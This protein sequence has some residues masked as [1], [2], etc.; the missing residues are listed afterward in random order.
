LEK[1]D[2]KDKKILNELFNDS[3]QSFRSVGR[4]VGLS[5]DVVASRVNKLIELGIIERFYTEINL[6]KLGYLCFRFYISFQNTT[7]QIKEEIIKYFKDCKHSFYV[8]SVRGEYELVL[9]ILFKRMD[10]FFSFWRETLIKYRNY[11]QKQVI[12]AYNQYRIYRYKFLIDEES[13]VYHKNNKHKDVT[14]S[15]GEIVKTDD[16][17][18]QILKLLSVNSRVSTIEIAE[19]LNS[20][21]S[22][23][24]ARIKKLK[25]VDV[26]QGYT[27]NI[28]HLALDYYV[29]KANIE[30]N[31]YTKRAAM[32]EYIEKN[33][34]LRMIDESA[35]YVDLELNF[36]VKDPKQFHQIMEDLKLKFPNS[37]KDYNYFYIEKIHKFQFIPDE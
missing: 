5:K 17:D 6:F 36:V 25:D 22:T 30:L 19:K 34:A 11:F 31:D 27:I 12:S 24:T 4:K 7:P 33:P 2:I 37:I 28:D 20:N 29:Y 35:G 32:I 26:I 14:I 8:V 3:R 21:T 18:F 1:I 10:D 23:I 9:F 15:G 16:L 13:D